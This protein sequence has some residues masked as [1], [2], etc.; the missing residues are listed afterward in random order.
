[1]ASRISRSPPGTADIAQ[2]ES[3]ANQIRRTILDTVHRAGA[4]HLGSLL[5][6]LYFTSFGSTRRGRTGQTGTGFSKW[7]T[8]AAFHSVLAERAYSPKEELL[9]FDRRVNSRLQPSQVR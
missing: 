5:V 4:G 2:L 1:M 9:T 3:L 6:A 8:L 7:H